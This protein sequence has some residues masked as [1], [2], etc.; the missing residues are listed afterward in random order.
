MDSSKDNEFTV[1]GSEHPEAKRH[2]G[3]YYQKEIG[4][5]KDLGKRKL[6]FT[7]RPEMNIY[8]I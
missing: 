2:L 7:S 6:V 8:M 4:T 3:K 5:Y 1:T